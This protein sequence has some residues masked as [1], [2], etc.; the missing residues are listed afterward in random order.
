MFKSRVYNIFHGSYLIFEWLISVV[1]IIWRALTAAAAKKLGSSWMD[2]SHFEKW[3]ENR[4]INNYSLILHLASFLKCISEQ[5]VISFIAD[6]FSS[7]GLAMAGI[8]L[9]ICDFM[10][11]FRLQPWLNPLPHRLQTCGFSPVWTRLWRLRPTLIVN[12][13]PHI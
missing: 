9:D 10:C 4:K 12:L 8:I 13:A 2:V 1:F 5:E 3:S 6:Y 11:V 7:T